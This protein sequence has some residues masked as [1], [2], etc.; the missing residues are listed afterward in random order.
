MR[1]PFRYFNSSPEVIRL[2][3]MMYVR[4]PEGVFQHVQHPAALKVH[5]DGSVGEPFR[6]LQS[7][8]AITRKGPLP[9]DRRAWHFR[10][11]RGLTFSELIPLACG[12]LDPASPYGRVQRLLFRGE[13]FSE[14]KA[15]T[16]LDTFHSESIEYSGADHRRLQW[17]LE[18]LSLPITTLRC[19]V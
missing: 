19:A 5:D 10:R 8:I 1:S 7:S 3:V 16:D 9:W 15:G 6:Q 17:D 14:A 13:D 18:S 11:R 4:Y 2:V 12:G